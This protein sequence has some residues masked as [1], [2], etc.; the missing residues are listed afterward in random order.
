[1]ESRP[2]APDEQVLR[3]VPLHVAHPAVPRLAV[4][5]LSETANEGREIREM[6]GRYVGDYCQMLQAVRLHHAL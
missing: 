2:T 6:C 1:V 3:L 5:V 4:A